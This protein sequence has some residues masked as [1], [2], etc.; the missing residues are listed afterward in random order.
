MVVVVELD[1]LNS[2][3]KSQYHD[4]TNYKNVPRTLK[5]ESAKEGK[6]HTK[7]VTQIELQLDQA[8]VD[9]VNFIEDSAYVK[10]KV[11]SGSYSTHFVTSRGEREE[12]DGPTPIDVGYTLESEIPIKYARATP[13]EHGTA[14]TVVLDMSY[15][16]WQMTGGNSNFDTKINE[17]INK[18]FTA[19]SFYYSLTRI[20]TTPF[21]GS[22]HNDFQPRDFRV[23]LS[24]SIS[25]VK[26]MTVFISTS[27][28]HQHLKSFSLNE[29]LPLG[30]EVLVYPFK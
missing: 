11:L 19:G 8:V 20:L 3:L 14:V 13:D 21:N 1:T 25:G 12:F 10:I 5:F 6:N 27:D 22:K 26:A 7:F 4:S 18:A 2:V 24:E 15:G 30:Y 16:N 23:S 9:F 17:S 29:S 28:S